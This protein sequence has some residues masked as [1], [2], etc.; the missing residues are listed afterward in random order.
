MDEEFVP[1]LLSCTASWCIAAFCF[2]VFFFLN[3]ATRD[4]HKA[5]S[6]ML[7][8]S[9]VFWSTLEPETRRCLSLAVQPVMNDLTGDKRHSQSDA[10]YMPNIKNF[11]VLFG[12]F[13]GFFF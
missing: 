5:V 8:P 4:I 12:F 13:W 3:R 9:V 6:R 7:T 2:L 10:K 11:S 1:K